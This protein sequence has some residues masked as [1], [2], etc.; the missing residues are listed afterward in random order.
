[1]SKDNI[2]EDEIVDENKE[3][4]KEES[5]KVGQNDSDKSDDRMCSKEERNEYFGRLEKW[6]HE[7]HAWQTFV[8]MFPYYV[9]TNPVMNPLAGKNISK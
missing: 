1:M 9:M 2:E 8:A 7:V 5:T 6:L 3:E 4:D